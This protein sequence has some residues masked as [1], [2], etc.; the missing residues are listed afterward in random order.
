MKKV[1]FLLVVFLTLF[2]R[3]NANADRILDYYTG[4]FFEDNS[5]DRS[6]WPTVNGETTETFRIDEWNIRYAVVEDSPW[7]NNCV[8]WLVPGMIYSDLEGEPEIPVDGYSFELPEG[9]RSIKITL[10]EADY[11]DYNYTLQP[12]LPPTPGN[13]PQRF[14]DIE[15]YE[16]F[17]PVLP[18]KDNGIQIYRGT[19]IAYV[20]IRPVS[21]DYQNNIV[22]AYKHIKYK[23][24]FC[25]DN[26]GVNDILSDDDNATEYYTIQ[27][28][29]IDKPEK[30]NLYIERRGSEVRKV[31]F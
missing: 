29:R 10:L 16:G 24:D 11:N 28:I 9:Y 17:F 26:A 22:R 23:I 25:K 1:I 7:Y 13:E 27:G 8:R 30:G 2:G 19:Y 14:V 5:S 12:A 4:D 6:Y 21:Y 20:G 18:Y 3:I 15:P 31:I